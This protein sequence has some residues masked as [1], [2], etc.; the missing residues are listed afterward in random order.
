MCPGWASLR[1]ASQQC[2]HLIL[3]SGL[4]LP[5]P[6]PLGLTR[7]LPAT[8]MCVLTWAPPFTRTHCLPERSSCCSAPFPTPPNALGASLQAH[9]GFHAPSPR[10][11][12]CT[13]KATSIH[14]TNTGQRGH[15]RPVYTGTPRWCR[16]GLYRTARRA[17][18]LR[19]SS[20]DQK[21]VSPLR[22]ISL[23]PWAQTPSPKLVLKSWPTTTM[24]PGP[25]AL[26][27]KAAQA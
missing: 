6:S 14:A 10:G 2:H 11:Q 18:G 21:K 7:C 20:D 17:A 22:G 15:P 25:A 8:S 5:V 13:S 9:T 12:H 16:G 27:A 4:W 1:T 26:T 23:S 19:G 3:P 24:G